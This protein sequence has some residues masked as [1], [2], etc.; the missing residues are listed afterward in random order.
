MP[1]FPWS[2]SDI[3]VLVERSFCPISVQLSLHAGDTVFFQLVGQ[4]VVSLTPGLSRSEIS[5]AQVSFVCGPFRWVAQLAV[6]PVPLSCPGQCSV[7]C[8]VLLL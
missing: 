8:L 2:T 7:G 4:F 3:F 1:D 6:Y 5:L